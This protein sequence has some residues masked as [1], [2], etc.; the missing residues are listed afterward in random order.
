MGR[1]RHRRA[2]RGRSSGRARDPT[3]AGRRRFSRGVGHREPSLGEIGDVEIVVTSGLRAW[4]LAQVDGSPVTP[5]RQR[6]GH[7]PTRLEPCGVR[8]P[9]LGRGD[10]RPRGNLE[11]AARLEKGRPDDTVVTPDEVRRFCRPVL[12]RAVDHELCFALAQA[13]G[14]LDAKRGRAGIRPRIAPS[15]RPPPSTTTSCSHGSEA[16]SPWN[17]IRSPR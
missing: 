17:G 15:P 3:R 13:E 7:A 5:R 14:A 1:P 11:P 9:E 12:H 4:N 8:L 16:T 2:A 10:D 6:P